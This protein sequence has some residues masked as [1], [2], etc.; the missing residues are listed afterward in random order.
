V[1]TKSERLAA[2][3]AFDTFARPAGGPSDRARAIARVTGDQLPPVVSDGRVPVGQVDLNPYNPRVVVAAVQE[4]ADSIEQIANGLLSPLTVVT[5]QAFV[6]VYPEAEP[7]LAA[8]A[9]Y[10]VID[11]NRRL[12]GAR[13]AGVDTVPIHVDDTL[14]ADRDAILRAVLIADAQHEDLPRLDQAEAL[15][16]FVAAHGS[17]RKAARALGMS[18]SWVSKRMALL[19]LSSELAEAVRTGLLPLDVAAKV[20]QLPHAEQ[21]AAVQQELAQRQSELVAR[22][23]SRARV[24]SSGSG[25][26]TSTE[27]QARTAGDSDGITPAPAAAAEPV[28]GFGD[29]G[30]IT[31]AAVEGS[32]RSDSGGISQE[33]P[34]TAAVPQQA[35]TAGP[36]AASAP[37]VD[38]A[39]DSDG[40]TPASEALCAD[41]LSHAALDD[42]AAILLKSV[43]PKDLTDLLHLVT[44]ALRASGRPAE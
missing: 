34:K 31:E 28:T 9:L 18:Q 27:A 37:A 41:W 32:T 14:A 2:S 8:A 21:A 43:S 13:L 17:Q 11:G 30:G 33:M 36:P 22:Q 20:G 19:G 38:P 25:G 3:A 5:R 16:V 44:D 24:R 40:I 7:L 10:V 42:I 29:S 1:S 4:M 26:I 35:K 39:G 6:A 23:E 12:A 15:Q